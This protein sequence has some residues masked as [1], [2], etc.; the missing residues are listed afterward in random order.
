MPFEQFIIEINPISW[1]VLR[2]YKTLLWHLTM[3][4]LLMKVV[5]MELKRTKC[6]RWNEWQ[7]YEWLLGSVCMCVVCGSVCLDVCVSDGNDGAVARQ[8]DYEANWCEPCVWGDP[9]SEFCIMLW[10]HGCPYFVCPCIRVY[11]WAFYALWTGFLLQWWKSF[12]LCLF[13]D[14]HVYL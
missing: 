14:L 3:R 12:F 10:R 8:T 11:V 1:K 5:G 13:L 2:T 4:S 6:V 7:M 9:L